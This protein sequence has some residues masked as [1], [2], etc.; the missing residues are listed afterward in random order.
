M[1]QLMPPLSCEQFI[2]TRIQAVGQKGIIYRLGPTVRVPL[3]PMAGGSYLYKTRKVMW[4]YYDDILD[5]IRTFLNIT[6]I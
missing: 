2:I 1:Q 4:P 3:G 5:H 6:S